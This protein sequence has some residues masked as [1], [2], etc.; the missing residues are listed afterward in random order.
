MTRKTW[1]IPI[2][3]EGNIIFPEDLMKVMGWT[4]DTVLSWDLDE[5]GAIKLKAVTDDSSDT[6]L[7]VSKS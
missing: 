6:T 1:S 7:P 3:S 2:D 5:N 4:E